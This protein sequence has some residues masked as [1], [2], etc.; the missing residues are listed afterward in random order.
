MNESYCDSF[1]LFEGTAEAILVGK[2][3][4]GGTSSGSLQNLGS[5]SP[6]KVVL[7]ATAGLPERCM[8]LPVSVRSSFPGAIKSK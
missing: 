5:D 2:G 4:A 1:V 8:P 6:A 7:T 3:G